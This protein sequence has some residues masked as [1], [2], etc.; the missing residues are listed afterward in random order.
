MCIIIY[1]RIIYTHQNRVDM[2]KTAISINYDEA[3]NVGFNLVEKDNIFGLFIL[4]GLE[5]GLRSSDILN[6]KKTDFIKDDK[7]HFLKFTSQKTKKGA[8]RPI[9]EYV[10][11]KSIELTA[12]ND[13]LFHNDKYG[14]RYSDFWTGRNMKRHF[15]NYVIK[16]KANKKNVSAHS[17]RKSAGR[18]I[19]DKYG[20]EGARDFLQ[21]ENYDTTKY[22]LQIEEQELNEKIV[23][24]L[25]L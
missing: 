7:K 17:L 5:T 12:N 21:H 16:A 10:Y 6:I 18:K 4:I 23:D 14:C 11:N 15:P 22:Y 24:A 1:I 13:I 20:I 2:N 25:S 3:K 9:S 19:Y 8:I